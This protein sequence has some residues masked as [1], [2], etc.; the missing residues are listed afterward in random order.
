[1]KALNHGIVEGKR[2]FECKL[3]NEIVDGVVAPSAGQAFIADTDARGLKLC[4]IPGGTRS[5]VIVCRVQ[6]SKRYSIT[7]GQHPALTLQDART[8]VNDYRRAIQMDRDPFQDAQDAL[9]AAEAAHA[10][11]DAE[12]TL[13]Q[14]RK[15]YFERYGENQKAESTIKDEAR[16]LDNHIPAEWW[17]RKLS[18]FT[19]KDFLDL[20][21]TI[22]TSRVTRIVNGRVR[23][24]GG[25]TMANRVSDLLRAMFTKALKWK[26]LIGANPAAAVDGEE[27]NPER[28]RERY[29]NSDEIARLSAELEKEPKPWRDYFAL[30]LHYATRKNELLSA[31][32]E[33]LDFKARTFI[34]PKTKSG[35]A[36]ILPLDNVALPI[37]DKIASRGASEWLFPA[38]RASQHGYMRGANHVWRRIRERAGVTDRDG[39]SIHYGT[40]RLVAW[41]RLEKTPR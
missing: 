8:K 18:S 36:L 10:T 35:R 15:E 32:W 5:F 11:A 19:E 25:P 9:V 17:N 30:T 20:H 1:L 28:S 37:I 39:L 24:M 40:R 16:A 38:L 6:K 7:L 22:T 3:T 26:H 41:Q 2:F 14:F 4:L 21:H 12:M 27:R 34:I 31:R 23:R 13:A 29:Y 33:N